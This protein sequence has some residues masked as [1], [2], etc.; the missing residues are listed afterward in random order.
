MSNFLYESNQKIYDKVAFFIKSELEKADEIDD[1]VNLQKWQSQLDELTKWIGSNTSTKDPLPESTWKHVKLARPLPNDNEIIPT[2]QNVDIPVVSLINKIKKTVS[3]QGVKNSLLLDLAN[4]RSALDELDANEREKYQEEFL[5]I[6]RDVEIKRKEYTAALIEKIR[7]TE[8][9]DEKE[10][11]LSEAK[12]WNPS[13]E[14]L[15]EELIDVSKEFDR[16]L[17]LEAI[18]QDLVFVQTTIN[19]D[20]NQFATSLRRLE[21]WQTKRPD[22]FTEDNLK[23][24]KIARNEY[25][26]KRVADG[27]LTSMTATGNLIDAYIAYLMIQRTKENQFFYNDQIVDRAQAET[28]IRRKYITASDKHLEDLISKVNGLKETSPIFAV[29]FIN[30]QLSE[31]VTRE[32]EGKFEVIDGVPLY[33]NQKKQLVEY[34]NRI[35]A[36]EVP[37][38][39]ESLEFENQAKKANT[40]YSRVSLW[41]KSFNSFP[42]KSVRENIT[43]LLSSAVDERL[44]TINLAYEQLDAE[45]EQINDLGLKT[46]V[47]RLE[48]FPTQLEAFDLL[49]NEDWFNITGYDSLIKQYPLSELELPPRPEALKRYTLLDAG[50]LRKNLSV[51]L[52]ACENTI[53]SILDLNHEIEQLLTKPSKENVEKAIRKFE[54]IRGDEELVKLRAYK[55]LEKSILKHEGLVTKQRRLQELFNSGNYKELLDYYFT[56]INGTEDYSSATI[57]DR[58]EIEKLVNL[59]QCEQHSVNFEKFYENRNYLAA[60]S[61]MNWLKRN[62]SEKIE[63][64]QKD[65]FKELESIIQESQ[66]VKA[67]YE[68]TF[69]I[70]GIQD[71]PILTIFSEQNSWITGLNEK[72]LSI[73]TAQ[74]VIE[75]LDETENHFSDD[76]IFLYLSELFSKRT[77]AEIKA[78]TERLLYLSDEIKGNNHSWPQ[79]PKQS[80]VKFDAIRMAQ[81]SKLILKSYILDG[82]KV[83]EININEVKE[84]LSTYNFLGLSG[85]IEYDRTVRENVIR[86][87]FKVEKDYNNNFASNEALYE[88]WDY[89]HRIFPNDQVIGERHSKWKQDL[90]HVRLSRSIRKQNWDEGKDEV[91]KIRSERI[92]PDLLNLVFDFYTNYQNRD[93][94]SHKDAADILDIIEETQKTGSFSSITKSPIEEMKARLLVA[95]VIENNDFDII[96]TIEILNGENYIENK[97][98]DKQKSKLAN[99]LSVQTIAELSSKLNDNDIEGMINH[100]VALYFL[101]DVTKNNLPVNLQ[102]DFSK[103]FFKNQL[104]IFVQSTFQ[105]FLD[106]QDIQQG[107]MSESINLIEGTLPLMSGVL[108]AVR[109]LYHPDEAQSL[110]IALGLSHNGNNFPSLQEFDTI[111][112][113]LVDKKNRMRR[114]FQEVNELKDIELWEEIL[115]NTLNGNRDAGNSIRSRV[116]RIQN[117]V[118]DP[119]R[120]HDINHL[121]FIIETWI[122]SSKE[123]LENYLRLRNCGETEYEE[124]RDYLGKIDGIINQ[125][126][127]L[128]DSEF[129]V[130]LKNY[131]NCCIVLTGEGTRH[132][133]LGIEAIQSF[134]ELRHEQIC[135]FE[136]DKK[137]IVIC[138]TKVEMG[139]KEL[140][141]KAKTWKDLLTKEEKKKFTNYFLALNSVVQGSTVEPLAPPRPE[142]LPS[143]ISS[144]KSISFWDKLRKFFTPTSKNQTITGQNAILL[145]RDFT[146]ITIEDQAEVLEDIV[147]IIGSISEKPHSEFLSQLSSNL[148]NEVKAETEILLGYLPSIQETKDIADDIIKTAV[149][150]DKTEIEEMFQSRKI[151]SILKYYLSISPFRRFPE[152]QANVR[153][154]LLRRII[155]SR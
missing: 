87:A 34:R 153:E 148:F 115:N 77:L 78:F 43:N 122:D 14:T 33:E 49:V 82:L 28:E 114:I 152:N 46:A 17:S 7:S 42:R 99:D 140:R 90:H 108:K 143:E 84:L 57:A 24:I 55:D 117:D 98:V 54:Q 21:T 16:G 1:N 85:E 123:I 89:F 74:F 145:K 135:H 91:D 100:I 27:K 11:L 23:A 72:N 50:E 134:L 71:H 31:R 66:G 2:V 62:V 44:N 19:S 138:K 80:T 119:L 95:E 75:L 36:E 151:G 65:K 68:D 53:N 13:D 106:Q 111:Y 29:D 92:S 58:T 132:D 116:D 37:S 25:D 47:A 59:A 127:T 94:L 107:S 86:H 10:R 35:L 103:P 18:R 79:N 118:I 155:S 105:K 12:E 137:Q 67:F 150:K 129:T 88:L 125:L 69:R 130:A 9:L 154:I 147:N 96:K 41:I 146:D 128:F 112:A 131:L 5:S 3:E 142:P 51:K 133:Y 81:I 93:Y 70:I 104:L 76:K 48:K 126:P 64:S 73:N 141:I 8:N 113:R 60:Q 124:S 40:I 20:I 97:L 83:E 102:N 136:N 22:F 4:L 121:I 45:L 32:I 110:S 109:N 56:N 52:N 38:E 61:E 149:L 15:R 26:E 101:N 39:K 6:S 63:E 144:V 30:N 139:I 120:F